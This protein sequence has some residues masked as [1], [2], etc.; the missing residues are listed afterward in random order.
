MKAVIYRRFGGP[1]VL[2]Y[3]GD[4]P[5]PMPKANEVLVR[6]QAGGLNPKD[7]LLRKGKFRPFLDREPLPRVSGLEM[8][9]EVVEIGKGA[10]GLRVGERVFG[11][12][13]RFHGG[14]HAEYAVVDAGW[15]APIPERI[16]GTLAAAV[17]LAAQ[18]ALQALRD[19]AGVGSGARV[20]INGASGGVGHFAVQVAR[21]LGA[22]VTAVCGKHNLA[23]VR[24][25]GAQHVVDYRS[26]AATQ[27]AGPFDCIFD[28]FGQYRG[29]DFSRSLAP[30]GIY[31]NTIPRSTTIFGELL[32]MTGLW[33]R[34]RLVL[35]R[36]RRRDLETLGDWIQ[37]G[38]LYPHI[39]AV[40]SFREAAEA[41]RR[42]ETRHV[43]GKLVLEADW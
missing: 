26:T 43:R 14:L 11:M 32:A 8:A 13:N 23:F 21:I 25:L 1:E 39:E 20:L 2:E 7:A 17:P 37:Q 16:S 41:H 9:G 12:S 18:T 19:Y 10:T 30:R 5:A 24:E 36:S 22:N 4:W 33:R 40:Y 42:L 6:V 3:V 34:S 38:R 28:V 27:V 35:V 31:V 29:R 15:V